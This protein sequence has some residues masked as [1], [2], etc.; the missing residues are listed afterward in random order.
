M[1]LSLCIPLFHTLT[2]S[3]PIWYSQ[4]IFRKI[5]FSRTAKRN[6]STENFLEPTAPQ[7]V[8][9]QVIVFRDYY[10]NYIIYNPVTNCK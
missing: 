5:I 1:P 8:F 10:Y 9:S 4:N 2:D 6:F 3:V 7:S